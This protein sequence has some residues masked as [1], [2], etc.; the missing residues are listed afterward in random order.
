MRKDQIRSNT[1][2]ETPWNG[3]YEED[4]QAKSYRKPW[5]YIK[6]H[7]SNSFRLIKSPNNA[8]YTTVRRSS[9]DR[10]DRKSEKSP[11]FSRWAT[12]LLFTSFSNTLL[13]IERRLKRPY[14]FATNFFPTFLNTGTRDEIWRH[15]MKSSAGMYES[16]GSQ[17]FRT[18]C[19]WRVRVGGL[20]QPD[21]YRNIMQFPVS[22]KKKSSLKEI[23]ESYDFYYYSIDYFMI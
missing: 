10:E 8:T 22:P 1:R 5:I 17:F 2:P 18:R 14:F 23:P 19:L 9:V 15:I 4:Q 3:V 7:S 12:S 16:L 21:N 20:Y 6:C 13:T 11:Y